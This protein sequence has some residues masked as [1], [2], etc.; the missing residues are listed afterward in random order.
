MITKETILDIQE[1]WANAIIEIGATKPNIGLSKNIAA[2]K[3][4]EL[5][6]FD[7]QKVLFKPTKTAIAQFRG[8]FTGALS[9]FVGDNQDYPEDTGFALQP[10]KKVEF[11]NHDVIINDN[12]AVA[13][14]NYYFTST[15]DE[16]VKVEFTFGYKKMSDGKVK[17]E[18]H[19]SSLPFSNEQ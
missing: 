14:G 12:T 15:Q 16:V 6:A 1:Q 11:E 13:M 8:N 7:E 10:W 18:L 4:K 2:Q 17:I 3:I 9:Y 5:Y 19:H